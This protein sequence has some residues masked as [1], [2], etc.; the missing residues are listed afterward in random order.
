MR[1]VLVPPYENPL[2]N[3]G[4][5]LREAVDSMKEKGQLEGVEVD[6]DEGYFIDS[7]SERRDEESAVLISLGNLRKVAEYCIL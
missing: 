1:L 2:I 4:W 6:V 3:W 5:I 7:T